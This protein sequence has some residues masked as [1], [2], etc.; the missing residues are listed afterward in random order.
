MAVFSRNSLWLW[1]ARKLPRRRCLQE[2][3][4]GHSV[5]QVDGKNIKG[6]DLYFELIHSIHK[7]IM[8]I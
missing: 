2:I 5:S 8:V 7:P 4:P 6:I 3:K 1:N